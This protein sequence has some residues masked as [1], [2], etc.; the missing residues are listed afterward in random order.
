MRKRVGHYQELGNALSMGKGNE[1]SLNSV[2]C[3]PMEQSLVQAISLTGDIQRMAKSHLCSKQRKTG[4]HLATSSRN[5]GDSAHLGEQTVQRLLEQPGMA[6]QIGSNFPYNF[7]HICA[8]AELSSALN[9]STRIE[10]DHANKLRWWMHVEKYL[11]QE[12]QV[13]VQ[14]DKK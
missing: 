7:Q 3:G 9:S 4:F 5:V 13:S 2:C 14:K 6:K 10:Y 11:H 8:L 12:K 1:G